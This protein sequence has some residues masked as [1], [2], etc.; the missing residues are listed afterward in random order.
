LRKKSPTFA[1]RPEM[2]LVLRFLGRT[3][4]HEDGQIT[5][6]ETRFRMGTTS[7]F[8]A[9]SELEKQFLAKVF[10]TGAPDDRFGATPFSRALHVLLHT[11]R[12]TS[13]T[14][15]RRPKN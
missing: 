13:Q 4:P 15:D 1:A 8:A 14:S 3:T 2:L 7:G 5:I 9:A 6:Q 12:L 11:C 10:K